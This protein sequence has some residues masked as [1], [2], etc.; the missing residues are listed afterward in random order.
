LGLYAP[1]CDKNKQN[2]ISIFGG[3]SFH[4]FRG[5]ISPRSYT[6]ERHRL[7]KMV[8][9]TMLFL[10]CWQ[11]LFGSVYSLRSTQSGPCN[12]TCDGAHGTATTDLVCG[13]SDYSNTNQGKHMKDCLLCLQNSTAYESPTDNDVYSFLCKSSFCTVSHR[14]TK[15]W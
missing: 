11:F 15:G 5:L 2:P 9:S 14:M 13:D 3:F 1:P 12:S 8:R 4:L 10:L 7:S 6:E